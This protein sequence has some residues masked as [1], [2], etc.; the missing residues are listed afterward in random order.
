MNNNNKRLGKQLP[1]YRFNF[2]GI[3]RRMKKN[4]EEVE[5]EKNERVGRRD[6]LGRHKRRRT[7]R[8]MYFGWSELRLIINYKNI[9]IFMSFD[10]RIHISFVQ[11][12]AVEQITLTV[13]VNVH[14]VS[15]WSN[16]K[17]AKHTH[18]S[19]RSDL[20]S[21]II[22]MICRTFQTHTMKIIVIAI[23]THPDFGILDSLVERKTI[24]KWNN[25]QQSILTRGSDK[26][27]LRHGEQTQWR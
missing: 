17:V 19:Q 14:S 9:Y 26:P 16:T 7:T 5:G 3:K 10:V 23:I 25:L 20:T 18:R 2:I 12:K 8:I 11:F 22:C 1:I 6:L 27:N 4:D 13:H 15:F 24:E 21:T